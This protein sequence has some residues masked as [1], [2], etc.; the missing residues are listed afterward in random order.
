MKKTQKDK[1]VASLLDHDGI[2]FTLSP[3]DAG[4]IYESIKAGDI[5]GV[6]LT[7]KQGERIRELGVELDE[8]DVMYKAKKAEA[9]HYKNLYT[10]YVEESI[11]HNFS[12]E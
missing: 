9:E 3:D 6:V 12:G 2:K 4:L 11:Y 7:E 10:D 1:F 8:Y 5:Y